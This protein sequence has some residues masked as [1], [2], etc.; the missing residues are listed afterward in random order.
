M[1]GPTD[2][3]SLPDARLAG[4]LAE[5]REL[6]PKTVELRRAIHRYPEE[7]LH[8]PETLAKIEAA[9]E[10]LPLETTAGKGSTALTAVLRGGRP[11]PAVLLRADMD[12]LP[13]H[14][15][16][17]LGFAS[18]VPESMHACGHDAHVAML[19]SAAHLLSAH[20]GEL[21]GSVVF[22]FQPGE[23]GYHGAR[24]MIHEGVL[25]A[26]GEQ[27]ERA[28]AL[29]VYANLPSGVIT[30]RPG[31]FLASADRFS[32]RVT[33]KGGHGSA[34][35]Q[36][37]D[38]VPA[39]AAMVGA[40]QTMITRRV[41]VFEPAVVSVARI[42]AGTT[43]NIIPEVAELEG[44]IRTLSERTRALV[45]EELPKVCEAIGQ[46][47]GCRVLADVEPGYPVTVNDPAEAARVLALAGDALGEEHA[48]PMLDPL[49]S[50]EDFSYVLQRVPGAMAFL[51]ACPP[52]TGPADAAAI[53]S[54]RVLFDEDAL[55]HGVAMHAAFALDALR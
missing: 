4:L 27:V 11:G 10:G 28:F 22:M 39:A 5:A 50:A 21:A 13:L 49:M 54:N 36:A 29:H 32:V 31:P 7:G 48:E 15:E 41:S 20:A 34:P 45:R 16:T 26:A 6:H 14:E 1:T 40:L 42:A 30:T 51:G 44:T 18:T 25:D 17:G 52:G 37:I 8:L 47:H 53:H 35:H 55:D 24:H 9:L 43:S 12:A 38:P 23:E 3:P 46:A 33:G 19:V 2:L